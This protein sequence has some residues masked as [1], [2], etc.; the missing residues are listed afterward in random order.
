MPD[1][2]SDPQGRDWLIIETPRDQQ[3]AKE[4]CRAARAAIDCARDDGDVVALNEALVALTRRH[5]RRWFAALQAMAKRQGRPRKIEDW[6]TLEVA[7][8]FTGDKAVLMLESRTGASTRTGYRAKKRAKRDGLLFTI[9][10]R[11]D[12]EVEVSCHQLPI[13]TK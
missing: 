3:R 5:P 8:D 4:L 13:L 12:G 10:L 2:T 1:H 11:E 6:T 7:R 9:R